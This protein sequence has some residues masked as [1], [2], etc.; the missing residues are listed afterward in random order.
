MAATATD[1]GDERR[2]ND[3]GTEVGAML[4]LEYEMDG[5]GR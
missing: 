2:D 5:G 3:E 4:R 1:G